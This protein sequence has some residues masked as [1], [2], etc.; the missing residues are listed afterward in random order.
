MS[1]HRSQEESFQLLRQMG[2][3]DQF[4]ADFNAWSGGCSF[5]HQYHAKPDASPLRSTMADDAQ[6]VKV[7]WSGVMI[8][9]QG[10]YARA[11]GAN[12]TSSPTFACR[13]GC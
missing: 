7:P 12:K 4:P 3:W 6:R 8:N 1:P 2:W 10:R 9:M 11:E 13:F 5:C